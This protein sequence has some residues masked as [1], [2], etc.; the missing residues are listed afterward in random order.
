MDLDLDAS[1]TALESGR[2]LSELQINLALTKVKEYFYQEPTLLEIPAPVTICGDIHGQF[3]D[4]LELFS[5]SGPPSPQ[6]YLFMG[7][8]VDRG[9]YSIRTL[10]YLV[11]LKLKMPRNI[12]LIRGNHESREVTRTYGFQREVIDRFGH[13]G[14]WKLAMEVFD[15]LPLAALINGEVFSVHGGLSPDAKLL[16]E[17][18]MIDRNVEIPVDGPMADLCWSDPDN[19][20]TAWRKNSRGAGHIFGKNQAAEFCRVNGNLSLI[21]RS[22]QLAEKGVQWFFG[23]M[24]VLVWSAPNYNRRKDMVNG[25]SV[26]KYQ[27]RGKYESV[28]F[29]ARP[30]GK[31]WN[32]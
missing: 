19:D 26:L 11:L 22:H 5:V 16:E 20:A 27:S 13:S 10:M 24:L 29:Q 21:T 6:T 31:Y 3:P 28:F 23:N 25:A 17:V 9:E 1:L 4:L 2:D 7:D 30:A 18:C 15:L 32:R 8:Y 14:I 12:F